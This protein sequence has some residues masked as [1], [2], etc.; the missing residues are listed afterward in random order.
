MV[1]LYLLFSTILAHFTLMQPSSRGKDEL[2]MLEGPCG[3][4]N[5][6]NPN[7]IRIP[8]KYDLIIKSTHSKADI[9]YFIALN[10]PSNPT[11]Y[12]FQPLLSD[13][14]VKIGNHTSVA[15]F[16]K[17]KQIKDGAN[18]TLQILFKSG[19]GNLYQCSDVTFDVSLANSDGSITS[20]ASDFAQGTIFDSA[21]FFPLVIAFITLAVAYSSA[22]DFRVAFLPQLQVQ[23][24]KW[25]LLTIPIKPYWSFFFTLIVLVYLVALIL[26]AIYKFDFENDG[27]YPRLAFI[28]LINLA[29]APLFSV[30]WLTRAIQLQPQKSLTV[31]IL[32]ASIGILFLFVHG[33]LYLILW[34]KNG[35]LD[36]SFQ[37]ASNRNVMG[38]VGMAILILVS[39][40]SIP[41]VLRKFFMIFNVFHKLAYPVFFVLA[42]L[43]SSKVIPYLAPGIAVFV[44]HFILQTFF[45]SKMAIT[46]QDKD[47]LILLTCTGFF[48]PPQPGQYFLIHGSYTWHPFSVV[49][50][51]TE[52]LQFYIRKSSFQNNL[53]D[54]VVRIQGPFGNSFNAPATP[55]LVLIAGGIGINP[56]IPFL[57]RTDQASQ[58]Y[59]I[60]AC[61]SLDLL[62]N[63]LAFFKCKDIKLVKVFITGNSECNVKEK[64]VD[65]SPN[66][67]QLVQQSEET[68][69][70][71]QVNT[72]R[73]CIYYGRPNLAVELEAIGNDRLEKGDLTISVCGPYGMARDAR[74]V[75]RNQSRIDSLWYVQDE[76]FTI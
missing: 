1:P 73:G 27:Y 45:H 6:F 4:F 21:L 60:W 66:Q 72:S 19:D 16:S 23:L 57:S 63:Y 59:L 3:G 36:A 11:D 41:F 71:E 20:F 38:V 7:R 15:D 12:Q 52:T 61:K 37:Q 65:L 34:A 39:L 24:H 30:G 18:G 17:I 50:S 70:G 35:I 22:L 28:G 64:D 69:S 58:I 47:S 67:F 55:T 26:L 49:S 53:K 10:N 56:L 42:V 31:H 29:F 13:N 62:V 54:G 75:A 32:L 46:T 74:R 40:T 48:Q 51:D 8:L 33:L 44:F 14:V 68:L 25:N 43:H 5:E 76:S 9:S 2:K